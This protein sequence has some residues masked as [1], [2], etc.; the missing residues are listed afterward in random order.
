MSN[1]NI[2][3]PEGQI[4][5]QEEAVDKP[6]VKAPS[7]TDTLD[8]TS[9]TLS[10][11]LGSSGDIGFIWNI[12][13]GTVKWLGDIHT[14]MGISDG[15][16]IAFGDINQRINPQ[17]LPMRL[18]HLHAHFE[19][20]D[21]YS[22]DYRMRK[23]DG[24]TIW[25]RENGHVEEDVKTGDKNFYGILR[26]IT[27]EREALED[28]KVVAYINTATHL[29]NNEGFRLL[30]EENLE[31]LRNINEE[32]SLLSVGIDRLNIIE[33]AY[34]TDVTEEIFKKV[35]HRLDDL[36]KGQG[37]VGVTSGD[38]FGV[39]LPKVP[40]AERR[41]RAFDLIK[42]FSD[43][44]IMTKAGPLR[45]TISIGS[46][47]LPNHDFNAHGL[48]KRAEMALNKARKFG[49][50]A[51]HAYDVSSDKRDS[52]RKWIVTGDEFVKAMKEDRIALAYQ[53][54]INYDDNNKDARDVYFNEALMRM[55]DHDGSVIPAGMFI[56]AVEKM[57]LCRLADMHAA[58]LAIHEL[59]AYPAISL[60]VNI[61]GMTVMDNDWMTTVKTLLKGKPDVA[62]RLI[63][64]ITETVAMQD[65]DIAVEF[66]KILHGLGCRVALDDFGA[67]QT[68]FSQLDKLNI[69]LVKIDGAFAQ[70][71]QDREQNKLFLKALHMLA[72][73]FGLGTVAEG[74]ESFD[75]A[76]ILA[77]DGITKLQGYAFGKP[78]LQ[79]EWL[80]IMV[81][82]EK[83][84]IH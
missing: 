30:V 77:A 49:Q 38:S 11:I 84:L 13:R 15:R 31:H 65:M 83:G 45:V 16:D 25:V 52:F 80:D 78:T 5:K 8:T 70:G 54:V 67:G 6:S 48:I 50:S 20:N 12:D 64:E 44:P 76:S 28:M 61:S 74:I 82:K 24:Q 72:D 43:R 37:K 26:D 18:K 21:T 3:I 75:D 81:E 19:D 55:I 14:L 73:G 46:I 56:P 57:G 42:Y 41:Y 34:G 33:E 35:G 10:K 58:K 36:I 4:Q 40:G 9:D 63:V 79:P 71:M 32:G 1:K 23:A 17:D 68:S 62:N 39:I 2:E 53:H 69:D 47:G 27:K 60:S 66:I 29:P 7:N 22:C 59:I 51:Y